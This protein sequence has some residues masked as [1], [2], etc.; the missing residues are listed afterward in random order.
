[1]Y[2]G[3]HTLLDVAAGLLIGIV[4]MAAFEA[5]F[6]GREENQK[7]MDTFLFIGLAMSA[8]LVGYLLITKPGAG[9]EAA[10]AETHA[11]AVK[12]AAKL[13]GA[14]IGMTAAKLLDDRFIHFETETVWWKQIIKAWIGMA[15]IVLIWFGFKKVFPAAPIFDAIRYF[16]MAFVGI[17]IYPLCFKRFFKPA[18]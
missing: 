6:K 7:L 16:L 13:L 4:V 1:M 15:I 9:A 5:I 2:L 3:V 14:A 17:G 10:V 18:A 12:D 11:E 8:C